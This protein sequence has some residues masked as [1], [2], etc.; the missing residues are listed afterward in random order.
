MS[1]SDTGN[2]ASPAVTRLDRV[3]S[4]NDWC[5][6]EVKQGRECPFAVFAD[7]QT[8]GKGRRGRQWDSPA[9]A[10]IY[11]SIAVVPDFS[12]ERYSCLSLVAGYA[13]LDSLRKAGVVHASLKWPNDVLVSGQKVAGLLVETARDQQGRMVVIIGIGVNVDMP[14]ASGWVGI[15]RLLGQGSR[16]ER[17]VLAN[18]ILDNCIQELALYSVEPAAQLSAIRNEFSAPDRV[19]VV[20]EGERRITGIMQGINDQCEL[21]VLTDNEGLQVF[22]SADVSLRP[23]SEPG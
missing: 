15:N 22:N 8:A 2:Q 3:D 4:T 1:D 21:C 7:E 6:R 23:V 16:L 14:A 5:R 19:E 10:N 13:V 9:A 17:E 11:L 18:A 20:L 12:A